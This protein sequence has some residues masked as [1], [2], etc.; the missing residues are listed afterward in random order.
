MGMW[1]IIPYLCLY[2]SAVMGEQ[3]ANE[4]NPQYDLLYHGRNSVQQ[5]SK[6]R[7]TEH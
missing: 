3:A 6:T 7:I 5:H 2:V 1:E 4:P